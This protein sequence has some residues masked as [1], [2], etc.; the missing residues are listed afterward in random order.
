MSSKFWIFVAP[1]IVARIRDVIASENDKSIQESCSLV[2][3]LEHTIFYLVG[4]V[5]VDHHCPCLIGHHSNANLC[6]GVLLWPVTGCPFEL[7]SEL[8]ILALT[9]FS[10]SNSCNHCP[11][12]LRRLCVWLVPELEFFARGFH[13]AVLGLKKIN[14][15]QLCCFVNRDVAV[16]PC[17][18]LDVVWF[19]NGT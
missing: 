15:L 14:K 2:S 18:G 6:E 1:M 13:H 19:L 4:Y 11:C 12:G 3:F 17:I 7:D 10:H 16:A 8:P 5:V 9:A